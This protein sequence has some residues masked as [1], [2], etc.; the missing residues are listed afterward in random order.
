EAIQKSLKVQERPPVWANGLR[1]QH[2]TEETLADP[3]QWAV[4]TDSNGLAAPP[5]T[6]RLMSR[7]RTD[8]FYL[9]MRAVPP[10]L[11]LDRVG[12]R[13]PYAT[14]VRAAAISATQLL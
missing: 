4:A 5:E 12:G 10:G 11:A 6:V 9:G 8:S 13:S 3:R 1:H 14:S 2:V 7:K